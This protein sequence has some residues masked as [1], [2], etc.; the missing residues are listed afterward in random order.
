MKGLYNLNNKE[1]EEITEKYGDFESLE[2]LNKKYN[3]KFYFIK[4]Q[5]L[6]LI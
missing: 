2:K 5:V 4:N 3:I 1:L 6:M